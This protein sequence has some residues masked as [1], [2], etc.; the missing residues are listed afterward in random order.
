[1]ASTFG[2]KLRFRQPTPDSKSGNNSPKSVHEV[3]PAGKP[4]LHTKLSGNRKRFALVDEDFASD[5]TE[6]LGQVKFSNF[7]LKKAVQLNVMVLFGRN[8]FIP[9]IATTAL[10]C[11]TLVLLFK[12]LSSK[13]FTFLDRIEIFEAT[14]LIFPPLKR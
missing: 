2:S 10:M 13:N 6:L 7:F 9:R 8:R 3:P 14:K 4:F 11:I 5:T 1:M 12:N